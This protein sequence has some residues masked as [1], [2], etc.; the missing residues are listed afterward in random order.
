MASVK[1]N[2]PDKLI[3]KLKAEALKRELSFDAVVVEFIA[4][5]FTAIRNE[6]LRANPYQGLDYD[7][8]LKV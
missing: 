3:D 8:E 6:R 5:G 2:L 7:P 1:L 4:L